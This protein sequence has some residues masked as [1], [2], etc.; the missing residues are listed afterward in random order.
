MPHVTVKRT[1]DYPTDVGGRTVELM[2]GQSV[3]GANWWRSCVTYDGH[4]VIVYSAIPL[5]S[6]ALLALIDQR[7][8]LS[9]AT[10]S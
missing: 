6:T 10:Q 5:K 8:A 4:P 7:A 3:Q 9:V 1:S 2:V